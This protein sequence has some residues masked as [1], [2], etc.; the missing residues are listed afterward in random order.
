MRAMRGPPAH[1][2]STCVQDN[3]SRPLKS[4][5]SNA[6]NF[7]DTQIRDAALHAAPDAGR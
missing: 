6:A 5:L 7:H 4:K 3:P 1:R 2:Y